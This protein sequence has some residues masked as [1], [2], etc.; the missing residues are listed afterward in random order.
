MLHKV[1]PSHYVLVSYLTTINPD[2]VTS[3]LLPKTTGPS[4]KRKGS[5]KDTKESSSKTQ[6]EKVEKVVKSTPNKV[7]TTEPPPKVVPKPVSKPV[8]DFSSHPETEVLPSKSG[9]LKRLRKMVHK[10]P[11]SPERS[12]SFSPSFAIKPQVIR[13]GVVFCEVPAPSSP[14]SKKR[15]VED[16]AKK[17]VKK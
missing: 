4:K 15:R 17:I 12:K 7:V 5:K 16:M 1:D 3:V 14:A 11:H 9:I 6:P 8:V 13:K 2:I 10:L